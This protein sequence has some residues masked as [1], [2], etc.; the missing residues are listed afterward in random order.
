MDITFVIPTTELGPQVWD[1]IKE[2]DPLESNSRYCNL[3]QTFHFKDTC[4][5]ALTPEQELWGFVSGYMVPNSDNTLFIWQVAVSPQARG[6]GLGKRMIMN[7]LSRG[8]D[9]IHYIDTT[10]TEDNKASWALFG[11][12]A[13][14]LGDAAMHSRLLFD[15]EK[16]FDEKGE[17]E[18][19]LRIG[20]FSSKYNSYEI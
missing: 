17:D 18:I 20:P 10:I 1:L 19:L 3:L 7:I 5:A 14:D 8:L 6:M 4:I 16:H 9:D 12:L 2:C 11:S 15:S 13:R